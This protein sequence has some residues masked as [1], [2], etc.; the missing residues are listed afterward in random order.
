MSLSEEASETQLRP[1]HVCF[2]GISQ[3]RTYLHVG[4]CRLGRSL[5][6]LTT[7]IHCSANF[8]VSA[9]SEIHRPQRVLPLP[10]WI[11]E[12]SAANA[13]S[14]LENAKEALKYLSPAAI[15]GVLDG[16]GGVGHAGTILC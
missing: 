14:V 8:F 7:C 12:I 15:F 13:F 11:L 4:W 2:S 16:A 6:A 5:Y 1:Q 3:L 9:L 10:I